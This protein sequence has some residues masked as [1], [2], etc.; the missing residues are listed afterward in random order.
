MY[1]AIVKRKYQ[2]CRPLVMVENMKKKPMQLNIMILSP[3]YV[4]SSH[5]SVKTIRG[6]VSFGFESI[7]G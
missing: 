4:E 1:E 6:S 5:F 7:R 3:F 2:N